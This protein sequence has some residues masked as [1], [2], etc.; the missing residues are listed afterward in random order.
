MQ[1]FIDLACIPAS[2]EKS[3]MQII[4]DDLFHFCLG[5]SS[6]EATFDKPPGITVV[7]VLGGSL[8]KVLITMVNKS[9]K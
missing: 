1:H 5:P 9:P 6:Q 2:Q 7:A 4:S 3:R 8:S